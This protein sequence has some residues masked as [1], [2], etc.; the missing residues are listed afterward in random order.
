MLAR[1]ANG[2]P[3]INGDLCNIASMMAIG[4]LCDDHA[5]LDA[6]VNDFIDGPCNGAIAQAV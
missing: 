3:A 2:T 5:K 1:V 4:V 6:A